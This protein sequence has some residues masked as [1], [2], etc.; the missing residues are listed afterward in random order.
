MMGSAARKHPAT[1]ALRS[2]SV[3]ELRGWLIRDLRRDADHDPRDVMIDLTPYRDA[4]IRL[5]A[6]PVELFDSAAAAKDVPAAI[7]QLA[8]TFGR[9]TDFS[10]AM[11]GWRLEETPDGPAYRF[12]W[13][14]WTPPTGPRPSAAPDREGT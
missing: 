10:L 11:M 4:A 13:P 1:G 7:A 6:S 14:R 9:R 5:G 12:A 3:D 8:R 2:G